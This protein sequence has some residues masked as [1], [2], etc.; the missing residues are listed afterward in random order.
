MN[1]LIVAGKI[2]DKIQDPFMIN[3]LSKLGTAGR[4]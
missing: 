4:L 2:F 1:I 3:A